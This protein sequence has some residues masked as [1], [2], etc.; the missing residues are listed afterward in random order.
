MSP[1]PIT[2]NFYLS[3]VKWPPFYAA[4]A[5][6]RVPGGL[7]MQL[8]EVWWLCSKNPIFVFFKNQKIINRSYLGNLK[9]NVFEY[10]SLFSLSNKKLHW[11]DRQTHP[12][13]LQLID[14]ITLGRRG[15]LSETL[16]RFQ[17]MVTYPSFA[18]PISL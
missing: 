8:W 9:K 14:W 2:C 15:L 7:V 13:P 1:V 18:H 11:R 3:L 4:S 6:I 10:R 17:W 12:R 5:D 16:M